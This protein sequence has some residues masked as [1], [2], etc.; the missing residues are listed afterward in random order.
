MA[1]CAVRCSREL[2]NGLV[3]APERYDPRRDLSRRYD[4]VVSLSALVQV[5]H[6]TIHPTS[7]SQV[8]ACVVLDTSDAREGVI[9]G[10][11]EPILIS[12]LGSSKKVVESGDVI[13]SRLRPYLRQVAF[14]DQALCER[15]SEALILCSTEFYVL[16]SCSEERISFLVPYLLSDA[17]Q[18]ALAASQEGGHHP[19]F[20][21]VTLTSLP[22]PK[23]LLSK[24]DLISDAVERA[25]ALYRESERSLQELVYEATRFLD[26]RGQG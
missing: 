23:D 20:N 25:V 15:F 12:E 24:K 13:V 26:G 3:L 16:R 19:R 22:V 10:R 2:A 7:D 9:I 14:V 5:A 21:E 8:R 11:K 1:I 17:V 18:S 6:S 4:D